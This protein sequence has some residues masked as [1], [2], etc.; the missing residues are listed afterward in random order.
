[1][2]CHPM[3]TENRMK[4][5]NELFSIYKEILVK[6]NTKYLEMD[7]LEAQE[8]VNNLLSF[9]ELKR[10]NTF[11]LEEKLRLEGL[12]PLKN[13]HPHILFSLRKMLVNLSV[14]MEKDPILKIINPVAAS[15]I[16]QHR[17]KNLLGKDSPSIMVTLDSS[18]LLTPD[19]FQKLI[20]SGMT[21][22]RINCAHGSP[23]IWE[24]LVDQ[25]RKAEG[26]LQHPFPTKIYMDLAG[27]KIRIDKIFLTSNT[28][29]PPHYESNQATFLKV[30]K[31]KTVRIYKHSYHEDESSFTFQLPTIFITAPKALKN[32]RIND[33]IFFDDG[34]ISGKVCNVM[35]EYIDVLIYSIQSGISKLKKGK[36]VNLPDSF[37]YWNV[38]SITE[39]DIENLPVVCDLADIIGVSFVHHP[40]DLYKLR[41]ILERMTTK[42]I[43]IVAKIETKAAINHLSKI[44]VEG[45]KFN[46]FG[47]MIAR[48]DLAVEL[49]FTNLTTIQE[50]M[51]CICEAAHV[52]VIW[53]TGVL[54]SMTKKGLLA[55]PELT[56]A[57]MGFRADCIM[58]NKGPYIV[59][60]VR[61]LHQLLESKQKNI[62]KYRNLI[63][64]IVSQ[65][66]I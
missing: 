27:P 45:L 19:I 31:G 21:I 62:D 2:G 30:K 15:Q 22:A 32:V 3:T 59:D 40:R 47:L 51:L 18:M 5:K 58:L 1:M 17:S 4:L 10:L 34:K 55:R 53:A 11:D 9:L 48:G 39:E 46:S 49:G 56:D 7:S 44:I 25:I 52:P 57:Y 66:D 60:S 64:T 35:D 16:K 23:E 50:N 54:E 8:S 36:G 13:I 28:E 29:I 65:Y 33:S 26:D 6:V 42:S 14:P 37:V 43:G 24:Q 63:E 61:L 12:S 41:M 38:A 20:L